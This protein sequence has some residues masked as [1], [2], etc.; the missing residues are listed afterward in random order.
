MK[1]IA[2]I[3]NSRGAGAERIS[4][5]YSKILRDSGFKCH[6]ILFELPGQEHDIDAFLPV[7]IPVIRKKYLYPWYI[8]KLFKLIV[9]ESFDFVFSS[10][11]RY[12][13][14]LIRL[15]KIFKF[16]YKVV[17]RLANMPYAQDNRLNAKSKK[18]YPYAHAL[19]AQ[20]QE[21]KDNMIE[22]YGFPE[23]SITVVNNPIDKGLINAGL[24]EQYE[25][26]SRY[27]NYISCG[28]LIPRKDT[29]LQIKALKTVLKIDPLSKL[30][31]LGAGSNKDYQVHLHELVKE[32]KLE[33]SVIFLGFQANPFKYINAADVFLLTSLDEGL[34][35]VM[36]EA[37][38]LGKPVVA[39]TCI[40]YISQV[41]TNGVNGYT[42]DVGDVEMLADRMLLAKKLKS[43]DKN[44]DL[45]QSENLI[46]QLFK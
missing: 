31:I 28:Q 22:M 21:M 9:N 44:T 29:A 27:T 4:L 41:V 32:L 7:D 8:F 2:I 13:I 17:A 30:Y 45:N 46:I 15:K 35:N 38:Y 37:M 16:K 12:S 42:I 36:L 26:D 11:P 34:P 25:M 20:T 39:T 23:S 19:I 5:L 43:I 40:P 18:Y 3:L 6:I 10:N 33:D 24:C 14:D 1:K